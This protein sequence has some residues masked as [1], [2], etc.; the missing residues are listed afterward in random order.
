MVGDSDCLLAKMQVCVCTGKKKKSLKSRTASNG[1]QFLFA[2]D[3]SHRGL[4]GGCLRHAGAREHVNWVSSLGGGWSG[5]I[6]RREVLGGNQRRGE[7][8]GIEAVL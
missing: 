4:C 5:F 7:R 6:E 1:T 2:R 3:Q 8:K